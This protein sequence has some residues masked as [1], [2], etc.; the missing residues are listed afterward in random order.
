MQCNTN[1]TGSIENFEYI[2]L[3]VL[4]KYSQLFPDADLGLSDHTPG[5]T[6]VLGAIALGAKAIEKHFTLDNNLEGPDHLFS[7]TPKSWREMVDRA[8]ELEL[9]MGSSSEKKIERNEKESSVIQRRSLILN[10]DLPKGHVIESE[11]LVALRPCPPQAWSCTRR[12]S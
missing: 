9:A 6:T 3:R 10:K 5:H 1:Y 2:N 8:R 11:D 4:K 7:M 12:I